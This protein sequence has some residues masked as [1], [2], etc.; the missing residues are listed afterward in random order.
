MT[1]ERIRV[2]FQL[3]ELYTKVLCACILWSKGVSFRIILKIDGI[4]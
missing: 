4:T 3:F 2:P 1:E